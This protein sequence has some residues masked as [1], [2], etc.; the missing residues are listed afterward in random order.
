[1]ANKREAVTVGRVDKELR[2][3]LGYINNRNLSIA[4]NT[5]YYI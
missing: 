3:E 2:K 4:L 1:M 5:F